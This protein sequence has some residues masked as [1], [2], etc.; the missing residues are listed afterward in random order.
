[1]KDNLD[2]IL[3]ECIDRINGGEDIETCLNDYPGYREELGPL[4]YAMLDAKSAYSFTPSTRAK[5]FTGSAS[6]RQW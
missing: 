6:L 4:L 1:M 2:K 5:S 3:D